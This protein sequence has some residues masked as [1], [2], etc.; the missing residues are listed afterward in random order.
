MLVFR[1]VKP[2]VVGQ[3]SYATLPG[4]GALPEIVFL[5]FYEGNSTSKCPKDSGLGINVAQIGGWE[6]LV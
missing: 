4:R 6:G 1:G 5:F 2:L 3:I